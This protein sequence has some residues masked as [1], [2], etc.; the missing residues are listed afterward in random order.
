MS[1]TAMRTCFVISCAEAAGEGARADDAPGEHQRDE[2]RDPEE[3]REHGAVLTMT[4]LLMKGII[5]TGMVRI[6]G[7]PISQAPSVS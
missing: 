4:G 2:R 1:S 5:R 3:H 7:A 6:S